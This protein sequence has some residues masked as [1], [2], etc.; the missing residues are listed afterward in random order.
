MGGGRPVKSWRIR[1]GGWPIAWS[2]G[3]LCYP[4]PG[5]LLCPDVFIQMPGLPAGS[6]L[7]QA[8]LGG[9]S[10]LLSSSSAAL[11]WKLSTCFHQIIFKLLFQKI[12]L[13]KLNWFWTHF[14][15]SL[16]HLKNCVC[17]EIQ[18]KL[19]KS[20]SVKTICCKFNYSTLDGVENIYE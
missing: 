11:L 4:L 17:K 18:H 16:V 9:P 14:L 6:Q 5:L 10:S 8:L 19:S 3:G 15:F 13:N 12:Y 20:S 2:G 1:W 7:L